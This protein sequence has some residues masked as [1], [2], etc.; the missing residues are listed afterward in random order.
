MTH[1]RPESLTA[2]STSLHSRWSGSCKQTARSLAPKVRNPV[3]LKPGLPSSMVST[4]TDFCSAPPVGRKWPRPTPNT[5]C[6][7]KSIA[8]AWLGPTFGLF[9]SR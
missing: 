1:H 5:C 8:A 6:N 4:T 2:S 7:W 3:R 9:T